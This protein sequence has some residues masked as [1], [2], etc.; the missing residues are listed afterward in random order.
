MLKCHEH[1]IRAFWL[2]KLCHISIVDAVLPTVVNDL[3]KAK[4]LNYLQ[5]YV[6]RLKI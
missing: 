5:F 3:P 6:W 2:A 1:G 4:L